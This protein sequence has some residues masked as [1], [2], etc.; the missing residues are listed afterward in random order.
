RFRDEARRDHGWDQPAVYDVGEPFHIA[1]AVRE[2][3]VGAALWASKSPFPQ[4]I[5]QQRCERH[6]PLTRLR[7]G[8]AN[9]TE[10]VVALAQM[11]LAA[12]E[13]NIRP[14]QP[15]QLR[16][17]QPGEDRSQQQRP[18]SSRQMLDERAYLVGRRDIDPNLQL[19][20]EP[21][22]GAAIFAAAAMRAQRAHD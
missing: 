19:A 10:P 18:P 14:P 21:G 4:R 5:D 16:R 1:Y 17:P 11:E 7:L 22:L 8:A 12:P 20:F 3:E 9:R 13:I 2:H 15:A 6:G